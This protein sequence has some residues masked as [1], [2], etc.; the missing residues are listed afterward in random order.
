[1]P[2]PLYPSD[3]SLLASGART[4][5][6]TSSNQLN[7][8]FRKGVEVTV[9]MTAISGT[10]TPVIQGVSASGVPFTLFSGTPITATG[11]Y[12]LYSCP[13]MS[14]ANIGANPVPTQWNVA[15]NH[16][17]ASTGTYSADYSYVEAN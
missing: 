3:G 5:S 16:T 7:R 12:T 13:G 9:A 1:M 11:T 4:A 8:D 15:M 17:G 6:S 14:G 2:A 10:V